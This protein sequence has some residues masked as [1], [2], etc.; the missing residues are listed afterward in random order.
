MCA[1]HPTIMARRVLEVLEGDSTM[2]HH[3]QLSRIPKALAIPLGI[4]V[5]LLIILWFV[6]PWLFLG[7]TPGR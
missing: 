6:L 3:P 2:A 7:P 4:L 1:A 5:G